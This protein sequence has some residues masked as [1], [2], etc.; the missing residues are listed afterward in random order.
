MYMFDETGWCMGS[1]VIM[2]MFDEIGVSPHAWSVSVPYI[3]RILFGSKYYISAAVAVC[4]E[5]TA[6]GCKP[7]PTPI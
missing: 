4:P 6:E 3:R 7:E 1:I 2:C 5:A